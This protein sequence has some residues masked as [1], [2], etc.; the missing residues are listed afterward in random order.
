[1]AEPKRVWDNYREI[2]EVR[3]NDRLKFVIAAGARN[4]YR[5]LCIREFYLR[6]RD[7]VWMPGRDAVVIPL[8]APLNQN[9][10]SKLEMIHPAEDLLAKMPEAIEYAK[11]MALADPEHEVWFTPK[12][13]EDK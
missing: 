1:M 7:G 6:Q 11:N 12:S 9:N 5:C 8:T 2:A 13:K 3:K 4:G 10:L